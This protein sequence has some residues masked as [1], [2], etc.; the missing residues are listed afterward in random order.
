[1]LKP[2]IFYLPPPPLH[3]NLATSNHIMASTKPLTMLVAR[4]RPAAR[5]SSA[6]R[7]FTPTTSPLAVFS[8]TTLRAYATPSGP[9][10]PGFRLPKPER[11]DE[12][13]ESA[14]DKAGKYFLLTEMAR[15]MY[16]VLEQ[17]FRPPW[18]LPLSLR[19]GQYDAKILQIYYLLPF[20][21]GTTKDDSVL[22]GCECLPLIQGPISPRFRG[23]HA[24]RRYPS[25]EERCIACKLC[26]A[27][28]SL[29]AIL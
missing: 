5:L 10:P 4:S 3:K 24:L 29:W 9:P 22:R 11:W 12:S 20:R 17:F 25:G 21:E 16:V 26:E 14:L 15:G 2:F 23:E 7:P 19:F 27:V 28:R 18:V 1:M 8:T 6:V 13:K